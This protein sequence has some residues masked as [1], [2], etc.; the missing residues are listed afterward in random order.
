ML[1][2]SHN[3]F[4]TRF[5]S[6]LITR[7]VSHDNKR[8]SCSQPILVILK[9]PLNNLKKDV[10]NKHNKRADLPTSNDVTFQLFYVTLL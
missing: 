6:A 3:F 4:R 10:R 9:E 5:P 8:V 1:C 7:S 2:F